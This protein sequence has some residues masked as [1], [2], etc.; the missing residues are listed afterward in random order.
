MPKRWTLPRRCITPERSVGLPALMAMDFQ[1]RAE[2][3][4]ALAKFLGE[5]KE[6]QYAISAHTGARRAD[7]WVDI[8]GGSGTLFAYAGV[9]AD[10]LPS[11]NVV[12]EGPVVP[13][14]KE[15]GFSATH[16]LVPRGGVAV[17]INAFNF[18]VWGLLEKF[19]PSYLAGM[20]CIGRP[21]SATSYPTEA[22][23]R[24]V[25]PSGL[26]PAGV[27]Q[28]VI[29]GT[30]D[31]LDRLDGRDSVTFTGLADTARCVCTRMWC[32]SRSRSTLRPTLAELRDP[33]RRRDAR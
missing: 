7:S 13:L 22:A 2:R 19:A 3:L 5:H 26:I 4:K 23:V 29:G 14:S 33:G 25:V 16:I 6:A 30:G 12:H 20:P 28:L 24:L 1:Q 21:A 15:G 17:H 31:L 32:A 9:G 18:L 10:E 27:L 8:E 11:G